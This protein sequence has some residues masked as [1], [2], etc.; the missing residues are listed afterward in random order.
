M[1]S[2][3][4]KTMSPCAM[5]SRHAS[6]RAFGSLK[7][8][9]RVQAQLETRQLGRS[10]SRARSTAPAMWLSSVMIDDPDGRAVSF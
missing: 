5:S 3:L 6:Q 4:A 1:K 7:F 8:G 10:C 9:R 2:M